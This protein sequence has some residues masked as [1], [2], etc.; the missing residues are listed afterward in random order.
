MRS[1]GLPPHG[2]VNLKA[3]VFLCRVER[4]EPYCDLHISMWE[5]TQ[6]GQ[7]STIGSKLVVPI[8][9]CCFRLDTDCTS[10]FAV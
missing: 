10:Q 6:A 9:S 4:I 2:P 5:Q 1:M 7:F 3:R 8:C